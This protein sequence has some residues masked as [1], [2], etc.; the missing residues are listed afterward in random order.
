MNRRHS[1][2][3]TLLELMIAMAISIIALGGWMFKTQVE[4]RERLGSGQGDVLV[5]IQGALSTY[6]VNNYA[7]LVN[8]TA[9]TG[10]ATA[11]A[12]TVAE[13]QTIGLLDGAVSSTNLYGG[14]YGI[15]VSKVPAACTPP[16]C[17][18]YGLVWLTNA[19]NNPVT[20]TVDG[21]ALGAAII[22]AGG[23]AAYSLPGSGSTLTGLGGSWTDTNPAGNVP[24]ILAMRAGYGSSGM[25]A[26]LRRDGSLPMTGTLNMG[27][28]RITGVMTATAGVTLC[29][30]KGDWAQDATTGAPVYCDGTKFQS[31]AAGANWVATYGALPGCNAASKGQIYTVMTPA[32]GS[33]PRGYSCDGAA[34]QPLAVADNG[35]LTVATSLQV[36][37]TAVG[38]AGS[39]AATG[40]VAAGTVEVK[41]KVADNSSCAGYPEG[42]IAQSSVTTGLILSCQSG[43]W[44]KQNSVSESAAE[45]V[46]S[47]GYPLLPLAVRAQGLGAEAFMQISAVTLGSNVTYFWYNSSYYCSYNPVSGG[48]L[49]SSMLYCPPSLALDGRAIQQ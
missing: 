37:N 10:V 21:V 20:G 48:L 43:S 41:L 19:I 47:I 30:T 7:A 23:D 26:F 39:G 6:M 12:P 11:M 13:L 15:Q 36:G 14:N 44:K 24:G 31:V 49:G 28:Q 22:K 18:L 40:A 42:A 16:N 34:W 29:T 33:G 4:M 32:A 5:R 35:T 1:R 46:K 3:F 2:G 17:N 25:A 38:A 8:G 9:V 45:F 27:S